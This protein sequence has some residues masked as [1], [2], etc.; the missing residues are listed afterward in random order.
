MRI[1][2]AVCL[3]IFLIGCATSQGPDYLGYEG[4]KK[5]ESG[6]GRALETLAGDKGTSI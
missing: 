2:L 1:V 3:S 6:K 5:S 4:L